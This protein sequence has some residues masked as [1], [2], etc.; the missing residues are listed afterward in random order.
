MSHKAAT[1]NSHV[2][3]SLPFTNNP[4]ATQILSLLLPSR[5]YNTDFSLWKFLSSHY[6]T[7]QSFLDLLHCFD[8]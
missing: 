6:L 7:I 5:V 4:L 2:T 1:G 8:L 3:L